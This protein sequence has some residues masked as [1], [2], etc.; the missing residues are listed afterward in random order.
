MAGATTEQRGQLARVDALFERLAEL[1]GQRNAI[2]A[3]IV[4]IVRG[5]A[6]GD[7]WGITGARSLEACVAGLRSGSLVCPFHHRGVITICGP[8]DAVTV[9][10]AAGRAL[11]GSSVARPPT[12]PRPP[13][14]PYRGPTGERADRKWY[15]PFTPRGAGAD[16]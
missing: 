15:G 16:N 14:A 11:D 12:R 6:E 8:A 7:L 5:L 1:Q 9:T 13:V 2:D 4:D 10:D 3:E